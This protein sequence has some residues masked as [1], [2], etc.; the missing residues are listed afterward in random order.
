MQTVI[1]GVIPPPAPKCTNALVKSA[2]L[3]YI[4]RHGFEWGDADQAASDIA[5]EYHFG[6]DGY[7]LAKA[8]ERDHYWPELGLQDAEDL[9]GVSTVVRDAEELE[10]KAWAAE[11]SI[12]PSL[13]IGTQIKQGVIAGVYGYGVARYIVKENGCTQDGRHLI[14]KFEDAQEV[15]A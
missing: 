1:K 13:P 7:Q 3:D 2:V 8:L 15:E 14:V 12:K 4:G 11:W 10:R 5:S 9:D 6:I